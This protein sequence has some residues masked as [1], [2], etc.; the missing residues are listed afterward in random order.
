[1]SAETL[2]VL[3]RWPEPGRVKTR[4]AAEVGPECAAAV[5]GW[6]LGETLRT[7]GAWRREGLR[8]VALVTPAER[9]PELRERLSALTATV[10]R[11]L[12]R[13]SPATRESARRSTTLWSSSPEEFEVRPQAE[14]DLG[15]RLAAAFAAE[16][17]R[18]ARG[19]AAIGTDCIGLDAM[20]LASAFDALLDR[21]AVLGPA[22]DGGYWLLGLSRPCPEVFRDIPWGES[23]VAEATIT[24]LRDA[25]ASVAL[26]PVLRDVDTL[27]DLRAADRLDLLQR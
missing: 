7:V 13:A 21:D 22:A 4:L 20:Q 23:A 12:P 25:G 18:G 8:R 14:G 5:Y 1:M 17:A 9:A 10:F 11:S 3:L 26:L 15:A 24:R 16:L 2:L 19:V 6:L 27:D